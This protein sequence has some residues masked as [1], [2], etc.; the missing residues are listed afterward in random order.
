VAERLWRRELAVSIRRIVPDITSDRIDE[1]R[2]FYVGF[3]GLEMAM[4][5]GWIMT[6][7]SPTNPTAQVTVVERKGSSEPHPDMTVEVSDVD[8]VHRRA[9]DRGLDIVYPLTDEPWGVR[10][11]FVADPNGVVLNVMSHREAPT[12]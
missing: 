10:R 2:E 6:F 11:F 9:L 7:V 4:N 8:A 3:L 5:M 12:P 1:S